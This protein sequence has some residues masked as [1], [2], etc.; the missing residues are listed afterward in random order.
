MSRFY[1]G[2]ERERAPVGTAL[3]ALTLPLMM[4]RAGTLEP[5]RIDVCG[6]NQAIRWAM[7]RVGAYFEA[8]VARAPRFHHVVE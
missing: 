1:S 8:H 5:L 7:K 2:A 6:D 3:R 4:I